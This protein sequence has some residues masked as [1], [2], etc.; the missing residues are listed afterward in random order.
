MQSSSSSR[1]TS[2]F[3]L[4]VIQ[5]NMDQSKRNTNSS[6]YGSFVFFLVN[7]WFWVIVEQI[8]KYRVQLLQTLL[9]KELLS[10]KTSILRELLG[11]AIKGSM[12]K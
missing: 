10:H 6:N 9:Q 7:M 1:L 11:N 3:F 4:E 8:K 2:K 12:K 5:A